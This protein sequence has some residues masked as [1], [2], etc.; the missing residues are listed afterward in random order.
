M[1]EA[2]A[3]GTPVAAFPVTGPI[4]VLRDAK[5]GALDEDLSRA[6]SQALT[7]DRQGCREYSLQFSWESCARTLLQHLGSN[8]LAWNGSRTRKKDPG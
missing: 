8:R 1:L 7:L 5:V 4:D 2:L 6:V 3:C